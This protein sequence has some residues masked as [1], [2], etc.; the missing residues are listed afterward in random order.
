MAWHRLHIRVKD[1]GP[2]C[3]GMV[4][5]VGVILIVQRSSD[6]EVTKEY[7]T[8]I[9]DKEIRR[10]DIPMNKTVDM[11]ITIDRRGVEEQIEMRE[12]NK[13]A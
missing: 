10:F 4:I 11:E 9:V 1:N 3:H 7:S 2:E 13:L 12:M 8:V 6:A 5:E